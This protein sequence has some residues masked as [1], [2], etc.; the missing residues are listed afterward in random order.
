M[1]TARPTIVL[2]A[3]TETLAGI[4]PKTGISVQALLLSLLLALSSRGRAG[5]EDL[6]AYWPFEGASATTATDLS[7]KGHDLKLQ[8]VQRVKGAIGQGLRFRGK[9]SFVQ[10]AVWED[11]Q[12]PAAVTIEA[13]I[14]PDEIPPGSEGLGIVNAGNY[15]MRITRG[16]P[17]FH[18]F[19]THWRPVLA[20]G[21]V[22]PGAWYHLVGT[23]NG[24]EMCIYVNGELSGVRK[25]TGRIAAT[26]TALLLGRQANPFTGVIDEVKIFRRCFTELDAK[27]AFRDQAERL[28]AG[29]RQGLLVQPFEDI[30]GPTRNRPAPLPTAAHLPRADLSFAVVTDT[31][32]GVEKEESQYCHPWRVREAIRQINAIQ[33]DFVVNCGDI[34]TAFPFNDDFEAQCRNA[35]ELLKGLQAPLHLVAGNHDI[36]NQR[37]M[38]VWDKNWEKRSGRQAEV[39]HFNAA[40][41]ELY[42]KHFGEDFYSFRK[43]GR[44]FI[45]INDQICNSGLPIETEQMDWLERQLKAVPRGE[46]V[47]LFSHNPLFWNRLDEPGPGNYEAVLEPARGRLLALLAEHGVD[48]VY[49][50]H[51][52]F[53]F[54]NTHRDVWLRTINSTTFNRTFPGIAP[55]LSGQARLYDPYQ[56]GFLVVRVAGGRFHESWVP[57]YWRVPDLPEELARLAGPRLI[58][59]PASEVRGSTLAVRATLPK[60][61]SM[62]NGGREGIDD[63]GWRLAEELGST[64]VQ[65]WPPPGP[66][67]DW[68][69]LR[70]AL[71]LGRPRGVKVAVPVPLHPKAMDAVWSR[72][73]PHADA[74]SAVVLHNGMPMNPSAPLAS[75]RS[76]SSPEEWT[77]ACRRARR[78]LPADMRLVFA[79]LPLLG[80][81]ALADLE[82]CADR[83]RTNV[84]A[85]AVWAVLDEAPE[86]SLVAALRRARAIAFGRGLELWLDAEGL[87][88]VDDPLRSAYFLRL[89]VICQALGVRLTWWS[90]APNGSAFLDAHLDPTPM[91]YAAQA[92]QSVVDLPASAADVSDSPI[93][94]VK[95]S[96]ADGRAYLAWWRAD[97][98]SDRI[99]ETSLPIPPSATIFDPLHARVLELPADQRAPLCNW[100][101]VARSPVE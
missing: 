63:H 34:I 35:V 89:L 15:L 4:R 101:L 8:G 98:R 83:V 78:I 81:N 22:R 61:F 16:T 20:N 3:C 94:V 11:L 42:R 68:E 25:R 71:T 72:L 31:H 37:S 28:N 76:T 50:G 32:I 38:R 60:P 12:S 77:A 45:V 67:E 73:A 51:T 55:K 99:G 62:P 21:P 49:T 93:R 39:M 43:A 44:T 23:Y 85:L 19:T 96:G 79:R 80:E 14:R 86:V 52:H 57:T 53:G 18:V 36:G 100:P 59:R 30:F 58:G 75:W 56:L 13:W 5:E 6:V 69:A 95:W 41:R 65:L 40:Y 24:T 84:D 1:M 66:R 10:G 97:A 82:A 48:A 9:E 46:Q 90:Q 26:R 47:F 70:R 64:Q 92:W 33:P 29:V 17:S 88:G 2:R 91:F 7:A 74:I 54:A 87:A 27:R